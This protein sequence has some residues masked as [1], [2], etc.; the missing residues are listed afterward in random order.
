M[1]TAAGLLPSVRA[2]A[3]SDGASLSAR[4]NAKSSLLILTDTCSDQSPYSA[5][6]NLSFSTGELKAGSVWGLLDRLISTDEGYSE[7]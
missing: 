1:V 7:C 6:Q 3:V 2:A 5:K 4:T